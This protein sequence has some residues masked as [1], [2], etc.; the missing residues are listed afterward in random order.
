MSNKEG[1]EAPSYWIVSPDLLPW[2]QTEASTPEGAWELWNEHVLP[3][4]IQQG[5]YTDAHMRRIPAI[6]L[7]EA[8]TVEEAPKAGSSEEQDDGW[9]DGFEIDFIAVSRDDDAADAA[10]AGNFLIGVDGSIKPIAPKDGRHFQLEEMQA[11]VGGPI[12]I[13]DMPNGRL[14]IFHEEGKLIPLAPNSTATLI[15]GKCGI[16]AWDYIAGPA[17][18]VDGSTVE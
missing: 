4:F 1:G 16:A 8:C 18:D 11:Y 15:A 14:L 12:E 7:R 13:L 6:L 2:T 9:D 5:W 10:A 17:L 3:A